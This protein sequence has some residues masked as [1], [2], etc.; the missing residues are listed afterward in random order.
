MTTPSFLLPELM[1]PFPDR[2]PLQ[3]SFVEIDRNLTD[4]IR[5]YLI[6]QVSYSGL[7]EFRTCERKYYLDKLSVGRGDSTA[8]TAFGHAV[9]AGVQALWRF[10]GDIE[11]AAA[12]CFF[13]WDTDFLAEKESTKKSI[14]YALKAVQAYLPFWQVLSREW[15]LAV[16]DGIPCIEYSLVLE[17]PNGFR[18]RSFVDFILQNKETGEIQINEIKTTGA[19]YEHEAMYGNS[20]QGLAYNV[21]A[22]LLAP[23][24]NSFWVDYWSYF[25][26]KG[27]WVN[28][29]FAKSLVDKARWL[30]TTLTDL[31][32]IAKCEKEDYWPTRGHSCMHFGRPCIYYGTCKL[33]DRFLASSNELLAGKMEKEQKKTYSFV[34]KVEDVLREYLEPFEPPAPE[35]TE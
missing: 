2:T 4:A 25:T 17:F 30:K 14:G 23:G 32:A 13:A 10:N 28:F 9:G 33:P 12:A 27:E 5:A 19:K 21:I 35:S 29:P 6:R 11:K 24:K 3:T 34:V 15:E 26:N 16:I 8:D 22:D 7:G 20:D 18:Y 1:E 31:D